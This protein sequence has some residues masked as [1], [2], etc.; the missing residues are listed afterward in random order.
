MFV[1]DS[2]GT[3]PALRTVHSHSDLFLKCT[4]PWKYQCSCKAKG[5]LPIAAFLQGLF[6]ALPSRDGCWEVLVHRYLL[7]SRLALLRP[8]SFS[9]LLIKFLFLKPGVQQRSFRRTSDLTL[10]EHQSRVEDSDSE[11]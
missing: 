10:P 3:I 5:P 2:W 9:L 1:F 4:G 6:L 8:D 11:R 7:D